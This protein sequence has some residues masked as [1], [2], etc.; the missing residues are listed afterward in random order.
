MSAFFIFSQTSSVT[1]APLVAMHMRSPREVPYSASS[2]M[3]LR[4]SGSPPERTTTG[5]EKSAISLRSFF[6]SSVVKS[7]SEEVMSDEQRQCT[8]FRLHFWVVSQAIHFGM[9]SS[10]IISPMGTPLFRNLGVGLRDSLCC[11]A[12]FTPC[13]CYASASSLVRLDL[14]KNCRSQLVSSF[15]AYS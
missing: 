12:L 11:I 3:S 4:S 10:A 8:H 6:P 9:N 7:P 15:L 14:A 2:K 13:G 5:L 1:S